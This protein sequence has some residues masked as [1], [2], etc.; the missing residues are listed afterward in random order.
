MLQIRSAAL[1]LL[2]SASATAA[3]QPASSIHARSRGRNDRNCASSL[4]TASHRVAFLDRTTT[5]LR[6]SDW[7]SFQALDDDDDDVD[8]RID[9]NDYAAEEDSQEYKAEM[10]SALSPPEIERPAA[11]IEVPAGK[12]VEAKASA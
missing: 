9:T 10:G 11:P 2:L 7:S 1:A 8:M 4:P 5:S 12:A 3:F 6:L